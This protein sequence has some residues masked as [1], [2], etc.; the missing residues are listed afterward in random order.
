MLLV[1]SDVKIFISSPNKGKKTSNENK[2]FCIFSLHRARF[3]V[4]YHQGTAKVPTPQQIFVNCNFCQTPISP[5]VLANTHSRHL[6]QFRGPS[7][8]KVN[9]VASVLSLFL[10]AE[11][12]AITQHIS[13][14]FLF[15]LSNTILYICS[16]LAWWCPTVTHFF[17]HRSWYGYRVKTR[18]GLSR[19]C[20]LLVPHWK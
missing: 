17:T 12:G 2:I 16:F 13:T 8:Q 20:R 19:F 11:H 6:A 10:I 1:V 9:K 5:C 7:R 14:S 4:L 3:D 18:I 15:F